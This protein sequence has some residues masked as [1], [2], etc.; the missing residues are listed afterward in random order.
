MGKTLFRFVDHNGF[1]FS[2]FKN[3]SG[4]YT[5]YEST[6]GN[7]RI[8]ATINEAIQT[9]QEATREELNFIKRTEIFKTNKTGKENDNDGI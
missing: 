8:F 6:Y 2:L 7:K 3:A 1:D 9:L 5:V 4:S